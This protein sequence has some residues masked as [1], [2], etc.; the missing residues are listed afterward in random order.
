M[1]LPFLFLQ[2][3]IRLRSAFL[4]FRGG[5]DKMEWLIAVAVVLG[6]IGFAGRIVA[7]LSTMATEMDERSFARG[8]LGH[9][10]KEDEESPDAERKGRANSLVLE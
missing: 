8:L 7:S 1:I 5:G 9:A 10:D 6:L 2:C 3:I 4:Q